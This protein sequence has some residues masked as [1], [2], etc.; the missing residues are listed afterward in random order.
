MSFSDLSFLFRFLPVVL[1]IYTLCRPPWRQYALILASLAFVAFSSLWAVPLMVGVI[2]VNWLLGTGVHRRGRAFL[3][4]GVAL[5]VGLVVLCRLTPVSLPGVSYLA[6]S[7]ISYLADLSRGELVPA[8]L[9]AFGAYAGMFPR[10][11]AGPIARAGE[12]IPALSAPK[13]TL[14]RLEKGAG[15]V[16]LGLGYKV[17]LADSLAGLWSQAGKIGYESLSCPMAWLS[18]VGFS[19]QL[20]YDFHGCSLMAVGLGEML[21]FRL[22]ENFRFPYLSR[23]VG[24]FYRRWHMTLGSW[25][26]DYVYI[27]LGGSRRGTGRTLLNLLVVWLLTGLWHGLGG[28]FLLWGLFLCFWICLEKLGLRRIL[29]RVPVLGHLYLPVVIV[30]SWVIFAVQTPAE[31]A[32]YFARL[33]AFVTGAPGSYVDGGDFLR[34]LGQYAPYLL[35]GVFFSLPFGEGA[36]RRFHRSW[37]VRIILLAVFWL[38]VARLSVQSGTPFLYAR[39]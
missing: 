24:E 7:L 2:M 35:A 16:I 37:P 36:L 12:L 1:V 3:W 9:G 22:P 25:F 21:G 29:E 4:A 5:D 13:C 31:L 38:C 14:K 39:F 28:N 33:F 6:F 15:L 23:S 26:R 10:L 32:A 27:P 11:V 8:P 34:N 20:Y 17:L 30:L 19:L 18:A